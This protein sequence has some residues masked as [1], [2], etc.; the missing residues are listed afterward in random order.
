VSIKSFTNHIDLQEIPRRVIVSFRAVIGM[1]IRADFPLPVVATQD[2][3]VLFR[4][5]GQQASWKGASSSGRVG[6]TRSLSFWIPS[7]V[8]QS[9]SRRLGQPTDEE[10]IRIEALD[11]KYVAEGR[12]KR[13]ILQEKHVEII[14]ASSNERLCLH[15]H[16]MCRAA[17]MDQ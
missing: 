3:S 6:R 7:G 5:C 8:V 15:I 13:V 16:V 12:L 4:I 1:W 2:T 14:D 9:K 17:E 11:V 10:I